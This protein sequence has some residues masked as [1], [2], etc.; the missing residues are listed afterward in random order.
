MDAGE[1]YFGAEADRIA[2]LCH[3][4]PSASRAAGG[5]WPRGSPAARSDARHVAVEFVHPVI[6]GKR[7][8]PALGAAAEDGRSRRSRCWPSPTTS[9]SPSATGAE[10]PARLARARL[11][12]GRLGRRALWT[13]PR[14][15]RPVRRQELTETAYHVLWELVHVFFD[16]RGLLEGRERRRVHDTGASASSTRSSPSSQRDLDAVIADVRALRR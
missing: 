11:P 5:C 2:R 12:D 3:A 4:L 10:A 6:V 15:R 9:R 8:L 14:R 16:H 1:R 13:S 7:A